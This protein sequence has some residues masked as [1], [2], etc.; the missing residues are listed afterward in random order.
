MCTRRRCT[1]HGGDD[2]AGDES[3]HIYTARSPQGGSFSVRCS[4]LKGA[5]LYPVASLRRRASPN[6]RGDAGSSRR[7]DKVDPG[8]VEAKSKNFQAVGKGRGFAKASRG[9]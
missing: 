7:S 5:A 1:G 6:G 8:Q 2:L 3:A 4:R 9:E